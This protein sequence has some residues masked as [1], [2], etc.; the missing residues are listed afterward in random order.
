MKCYFKMNQHPVSGECLGGVKMR[1]HDAQVSC[2]QKTSH[3]IQNLNAQARKTTKSPINL[4]T[5]KVKGS[6]T[7]AF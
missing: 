5:E 4:V 3:S 7:E 2:E 1:S 6:G